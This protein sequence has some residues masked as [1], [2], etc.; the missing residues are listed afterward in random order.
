MTFNPSTLTIT[1]FTTSSAD[2][3]TYPLELR[4]TISGT[5]V[6]FSTFFDFIID[7]GTCGSAPTLTF[8]SDPLP[9]QTF[10]VSNAPFIYVIPS[11]TSSN[12]LCGSVTYT[13]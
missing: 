6:A 4:G 13:I 10:I 2:G 9:T 12:T 1:T 7:P 5:S 8:P 3:G 11:A